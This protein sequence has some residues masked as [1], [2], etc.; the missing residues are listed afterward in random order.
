MKKTNFH[1]NET[2]TGSIKKS[3]E[4]PQK[5]KTRTAIQSSNATSWYLFREIKSRSQR[6][7]CTLMFIA[8]WFTAVKK[9]KQP[10][11]PPRGKWVKKMTMEFY[12][13]MK[14]RKSCSFQQQG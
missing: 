1:G 14:R 10:Q 7:S 3:H 5:I 6:G 12:P 9:W 11:G 2:G 4:V 13:A 8:G